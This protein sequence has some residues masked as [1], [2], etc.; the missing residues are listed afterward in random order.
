ME[1]MD[2]NIQGNV[3][4]LTP[5]EIKPSDVAKKPSGKNQDGL[6]SLLKSRLS[7]AKKF[8]EKWLKEVKKW[9]KDYEIDSFTTTEELHNKLQIPYIFS[10][11]ESALPSMF[12][13][14]PQL[15]LKGRGK[16]DQD[17]GDFVTNIWS[18]IYKI[19]GFEEKVEN[20]GMMFLVAGMGQAEN[21]WLT[22][23]EEIEENIEQPITNSDG[24]PVIGPDGQQV[25]QTITN[26]YN[27]VTKDVPVLE[28][29]RYDKVFYSPESEFVVDDYEGKIP[30]MFEHCPMTPDEIEDKYQKKVDSDKYLDTK[31][32]GFSIDL[33]DEQFQK[34]DLKRVDV[35]KYQ[36]ILPK[37]F[38]DEK[39]WK[40]NRVYSVVITDTEVLESPKKLSKKSIK[41]IGNYGISTKFHRFGE[42]KILRELEQDISY[43]RS[44]IMDYRDRFATKIA[45]PAQT[46][47][48]ER[49]LKDPRK[50]LVVRYN[51][52]Q[53]PSY[54]S[55]PA[56]PET[57]LTAIQESRSDIQMTSAQ[58]DIGRG[59]Q[60]TSV[61]TA[62][63]QKI[64]QAAQDDRIERKRRKIAHFIEV[65]ARDMLLDCANNW[66]VDM[67]A[68]IVDLEAA[69]PKLTEYVNK[70]KGIGD[71]FDIEIEP[72]TVVNNKA[73]QGAQS[74]AMYR[75][76]KQDSLVNR[77]E[78]IR[79]VIKSGFNKKDVERFIASDMTPEQIIGV[80][81]MLIQ[82]QML[83]PM[84]GQQ[85]LMQIQQQTQT[86][87][88]APGQGGQVP[89]NVG[90]PPSADAA[91]IMKKSMPG[92]DE[93]QIQAQTEAA[94]KQTGVAKGPQG[95]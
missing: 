53:P 69:D 22:E 29:K 88:G 46:E 62:T 34:D 38:C 92:S 65:L 90:R 93:T 55:P 11:V 33:E 42:P 61:D 85:I 17:F 5:R 39:E 73:T 84:Q 60:D 64:F 14:F 16:A 25:T 57:I 40:C 91:S 45:L 48:D 35:Y 18:Y 81:Q 15:I 83:D 82:N 41:Q 95:L 87:G 51:G 74:I 71:E 21:K 54:M 75:E 10:T 77:A 44:S 43:G 58:L 24:T 66:D 49:A 26:K 37:K 80:V 72:E 6:V 52:Q 20:A 31:S 67:F 7:I 9:I 94:G 12:N 23:T 79:E 8:H 2:Q 68:K 56:M 76:M 50:F 70:L 63:G 78:L 1:P 59:G 27:V 32:V 30:Y 36:G 13:S 4:P 19:T 47:V 86:A 3:E 28:I 89:N